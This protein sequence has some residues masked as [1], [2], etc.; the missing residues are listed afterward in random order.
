MFLKT[1]IPSCDGIVVWTKSKILKANKK[2]RSMRGI[3]KANTKLGPELTRYFYSIVQ[4]VFPDVFYLKNTNFTRDII[5][6][7]R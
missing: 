7:D 5:L 3:F 4:L 6:T 1:N 2:I